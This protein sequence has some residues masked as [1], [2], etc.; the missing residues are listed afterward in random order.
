MFG[1]TKKEQFT[2]YLD[3]YSSNKIDSNELYNILEKL[4]K[5][6]KKS[7]VIKRSYPRARKNCWKCR[8]S[9]GGICVEHGG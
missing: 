6:T 3:R 8:G 7:K 1:I 5:E 4:F 9:C 2:I